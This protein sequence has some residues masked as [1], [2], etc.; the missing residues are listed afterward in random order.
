MAKAQKPTNGTA[1]RRSRMREKIK[2]VATELLVRHGLN[3][4]S[5]RDVAERLDITTTNIHYH[6]GNKEKL[7]EEVTREY[8]ANTSARQRQIWLDLDM[9]LPEKLREVAHYNFERYISFNPGNRGGE[10]WSLIGRLRLDSG[11]LNVETREVLSSFSIELRAA[12]KVAVEI[13]LRK[14]EL[15]E[16][17]PTDDIAFL[18]VNLV[19]SSS[20]F[21]QDAGSFERLE[22]FYQA[23][24]RAVL[25]A[26]SRQGLDLWP[27]RP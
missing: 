16:N 19:N 13:A 6:F 27:S 14:G 11:A 15:V 25:G 3:G 21:T 12:V 26:Y 2:A 24:S 10:P 1:A 22:Q 23:F 5:F 17:A 9:S 4:M 20:V 8:V 18:I 7:V